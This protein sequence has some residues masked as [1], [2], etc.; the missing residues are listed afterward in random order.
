MRK[1]LI[2]AAL[3]IGL[4][5]IP[6]A[7]YAQTVPYIVFGGGGNAANVQTGD[8]VP[9]ELVRCVNKVIKSINSTY[10]QAAFAPYAS[11]RNF[12][13]NGEMAI[14]QRDAGTPA[15]HTCGV[16]SG[17]PITAYSADRWGCVVNVTSGAGRQIYATTSPPLGFTNY[18]TIYRTSGALLQP[19]CSVQEIETSRVIQLQGQTITLS[20]QAEALAGLVADNGG[21]ISS[22]IVAGTGTDQGLGTW[23]ASPAITPAWTG[24]NVISNQAYTITAAWAPYKVSV[25][26]P[27]AVTEMAVE[28]CFTPTAT[29]AGVTDGFAF[30][31]VQLEAGPNASVFEHHPIEQD[32]FEAQRFY[33]QVTDNLAST[34][35]F[36]LGQ[37]TTT[38][39]ATFVIP[40]P[41]TMRAA[42]TATASAV[43]AFGDTA[44]NGTA[45]AC[46]VNFAVVASATTPL[47]GAVV[48]P[49]GTTTTAGFASQLVGES[50]GA[51]INFSADF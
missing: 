34:H 4:A 47:S 6:A 45:T 16:A 37:A 27:V 17:V 49:T 46:T 19:V 42:P 31:G 32:L 44:A 28:L 25:N 3:S 1:L 26:V 12:I 15:I 2:P 24:I 43:A 39:S 48:C 11:V 41:V 13:D 35:V 9:A 38:T 29:G 33:Y 21:A 40:F 14:V 22:V 8:C 10:T 18:Q 50:T 20:F 7:I 36:A 5:L 30:T 51:N 23:T